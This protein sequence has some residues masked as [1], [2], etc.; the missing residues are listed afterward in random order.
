M[1]R[2]YKQR[3]LE[4]ARIEKDNI[5]KEKQ[6]LRRQQ[7]IEDMKEQWLGPLRD[8][9]GR[10]SHNFTNFFRSMRCAGEVDLA[11]P[12]NPVCDHFMYSRVASQWWGYLREGELENNFD[13]LEIDQR[14]SWLQLNE[15]LLLLLLLLNNGQPLNLRLCICFQDDFEKYGIRIKVKFRDSES[16]R[17]LTATH[18][19]GGEKSVATVLYMMSLQELTPCP[20]R[21]VDEI[22]QVC[23]ELK[24][25]YGLELSLPVNCCLLMN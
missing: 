8:L 2:E 7:D 21:C 3:K 6:L 24:L 19:S 5:T 10:I 23:D 1:V 11:V 16:L 4:I 12:D 15:L 22:N 20:F 14:S 17:E 25:W 13:L 9:I 18:Q